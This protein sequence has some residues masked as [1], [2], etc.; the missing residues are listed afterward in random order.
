MLT[1]EQGSLGLEDFWRCM[2]YVLQLGGTRDGTTDWDEAFLLTECIHRAFEDSDGV[3][4]F[5]AITCGLSIL[6]QSTVEDK[7]RARFQNNNSVCF[8]SVSL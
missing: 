1:A 8:L 2:C 7:V 6:C 4:A 5:A 3:V